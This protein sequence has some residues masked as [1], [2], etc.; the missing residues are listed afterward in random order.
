MFAQFVQDF[1]H[2]E[3]GQD[4]FDQ[5]GRLDRA[6]RQAQFVLRHDED[7]VPQA[8]FQVRF[9]LRQVEVRTGAARQLLLGV[10][11]HEQGEVEDAAGDALAVDQHVLFIEVPAARTHDQGGDLVVELVGLAVLLERNRAAHGVAHIDL[12]GDLVVPVR[13]VRIFEVGHV[14]VGAGVEG[15]D[16]HLAL[17]RTGDFHAA[18]FQRLRNRRDLPVAVA[19]VRGF[20]RKSGRSPASRRLARSTRTASNSWRRGSKARVSLATSASAS[21]SG[22]VRS[23]A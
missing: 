9:H 17:D 16:D 18:A 5:H 14:A 23:R 8:R 12:A 6:L 10:V 2:L 3:G 4:G 15:V 13:R 19:D 11:E 1:V 20:G 22:S 21:A 7:V